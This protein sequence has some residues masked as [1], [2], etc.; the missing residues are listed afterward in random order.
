V[1]I[2]LHIIFFMLR[3]YNQDN[4]KFDIYLLSNLEDKCE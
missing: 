1:R 2:Y 4:N 3:S